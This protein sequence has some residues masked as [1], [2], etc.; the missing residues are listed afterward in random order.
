MAGAARAVLPT[1]PIT[2][3]RMPAADPYRILLGDPALPH[4]VDGR[5]YVIDGND[6]RFLGMLGTGFSGLTTRSRDGSLIFVATTY[7][8]RLQRGTRTDVVEIYRADDLTFQREVQIPAKHAQALQVRAMLNTTAD[9]RFLLVQNATPGSSVTVVDIKGAR[10]SAEIETPGCWGAIPWPG[11][12]SRFSA[13]C[14]DG[15]IATWVLDDKGAL[16]RQVKGV[17]FFDAGKDPMFIHYDMIGD[18][19]FFVSYAGQVRSAVFKGEQPVPGEAW[20]LLDAQAAKGG[21]RPGGYQ[22]FAIEPR[23]GRLYVGMHDKASEGSHKNPAR[24]IWAFDVRS[25]ARLG[26]LP[27]QAAIGMAIARADAPRLFLVSG[28]DNTLVSYDVG[29]NG[30]PKQPLKRSAP[31]GDTPVF[32]ALP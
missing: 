10:V 5:T 23:S 27:G 24:E 3:T 1:E 4:I 2:T 8:S 19:L 9:D 28:A 26:R 25:H 22:L 16:A 12:W 11:D 7:H 31:V 21:W 29:G 32:L 6:M 14:G 18:E 20:S 17:P 15:T 13:L 30:V